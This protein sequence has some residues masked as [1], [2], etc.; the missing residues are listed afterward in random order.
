[1]EAGSSLKV[2]ITAAILNCFLLALAAAGWIITFR[3]WGYIWGGPW[4]FVDN[5][6]FICQIIG[7]ITLLWF[8]LLKNVA[9]VR[10]MIV[11]TL[12]AK[13]ITYPVNF[14]FWVLLENERS[15]EGFFNYSARLFFGLF[16]EMDFYRS[17]PLFLTN[18]LG[19]L[20]AFL[21]I[22][23]LL[24]KPNQKLTT[25]PDR[26]K[27]PRK[28]DL[29]MSLAQELERLQQMYQSGALTEAEF[30]A[31]KKRVLGN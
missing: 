18:L 16:P 12:F 10:K 13:F 6:L 4:G 22:Y 25:V 3:G 19:Y 30:T 23:S 9:L 7:G 28:P 24:K 17:I 15:D 5:L 14:A 1:M 11:F 29:S 8:L 26:R 31:A 21:L 20:V 27:L 2:P